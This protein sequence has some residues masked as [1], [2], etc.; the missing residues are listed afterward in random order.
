MILTTP[1]PELPKLF[2][3][4]EFA[5]YL[6]VSIHTV[7]R[8]RYR[9]RIGHLRFGFRVY[10]TAEH[11]LDY[12]NRNQVKP[13]YEPN[14]SI[15]DRSATNGFRNARTAQPGAE[16]GST[17]ALDRHAAHRLAQQTFRKQKS[18]LPSG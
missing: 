2:S 8:E 1:P 3:E 11:A 9:G 7:R 16:P 4:R 17:T 5:E 18:D 13:C 10:Y 6:G 14:Q 15:P 12:F